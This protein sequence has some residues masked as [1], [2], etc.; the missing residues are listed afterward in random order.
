MKKY[1]IEYKPFLL[2]IGTFFLV[3]VLLMVLYQFY[4]NSF[5]DLKI[6]SITKLV[7]RNTASILQ[8]FSEGTIQEDKAIPYIKLFYKQKYVARI[9]EG[10]NAMSVIILFI[11]FVVAFSGKFK[12]TLL[13]ILCGSAIIYFLNVLRIALLAVALYHF[14]E[15]QH[16]L[17]GVIFPLVIYGVVFILWVV[18]V[19]KFSKYATKTIKS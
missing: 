1:F 15:L 11:S 9:I 2:F 6:D 17:H 19:N 5:G 7:A 16:I 12:T 18:W 13:F 10:C 8:L 14:K 3:Y 4:L